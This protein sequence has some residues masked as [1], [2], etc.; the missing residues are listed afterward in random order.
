MATGDP[1]E[2]P[3]L[4]TGWGGGGGGRGGARE[5]KYFICWLLPLS[6]PGNDYS[7]LLDCSSRQWPEPLWAGRD[8]PQVPE[9]LRLC[10]GG[11]MLEAV[12]RPRPWGRLRGL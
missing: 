2:P 8:Q 9:R 4:G 1:V 3:L 11:G 7:I 10:C 6:L 5:D 12:L